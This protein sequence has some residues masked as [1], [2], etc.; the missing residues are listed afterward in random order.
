[1]GGGV[2]V[3]VNAAASRRGRALRLR[4]AGGRHRLLSRCRRDLSSCRGSPHRA[5]VY[6]ALTGLRAN[7]GDALAFGLAQTFVPSAAHRRP[8]RG[9]GRRGAGR[10]DARPLRRRPRR[11]PPLMSEVGRR[12]RPAFRS[13]SREAI[14][15][16]LAAP[17]A[18]GFAFAGPARAAMLEKSPTS[19]AI[20]LE[21]D[22]ARTCARISTR[23]CG[24]STASFRGSAAAMISTKAC[25]PSSSTRTTARTGA[26]PP[27]QAEVDGYFAPLGD[28]EL[29]FPARR[30]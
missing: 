18:K 27:S 15:A 26:P 14:L 25:A 1:M 10:G 7:A 9:A 8:G 29:T 24:S 12:S 5:G 11:L 19:Q 6:F 20:A 13:T 28:D 17:S 16:A 3:S 4:H 21:A 22:G 30:A 2:G 23:P